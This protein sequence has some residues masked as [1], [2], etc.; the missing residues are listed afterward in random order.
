MEYTNTPKPDDRSD[1]ARKIQD[2]I[3]NTRENINEAEA[4]MKFGNEQDRQNALAKNQ[5]REEAIA[6]LESELKD[7]QAFNN[8]ND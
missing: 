3:N 7:E 5:R 8:T 4:S 1:N 2:N 6:A